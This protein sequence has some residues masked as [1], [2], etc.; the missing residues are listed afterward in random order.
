M[1]CLTHISF[2]MMLHGSN[3]SDELSDSQGYLY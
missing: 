1:K 2:Y 3:I